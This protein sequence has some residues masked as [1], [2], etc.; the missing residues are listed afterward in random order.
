M[1]NAQIAQLYCNMNF[2]LTYH[3]VSNMHLIS[4]IFIRTKV[5]KKQFM[6]VVWKTRFS[7]CPLLQCGG[8]CRYINK[9]DKIIMRV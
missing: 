8:N 5:L 6:I 2:I 3:I 9:H 1:I 7:N 4:T